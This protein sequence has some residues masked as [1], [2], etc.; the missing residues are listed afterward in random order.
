MDETPHGVPHVVNDIAIDFGLPPEVPTDAPPIADEAVSIGFVP[1][2]DSP[3]RIIGVRG[4]VVGGSSPI[5]VATKKL[6]TLLDG[7]FVTV[8]RAYDDRSDAT[9]WEPDGKSVERVLRNPIQHEDQKFGWINDVQVSYDGR[10]FL[11]RPDSLEVFASDLSSRTLMDSP[12]GRLRQGHGAVLSESVWVSSEPTYPGDHPD[13]FHTMTP[14][15]SEVSSFC[16]VPPGIPRNL[17]NAPIPRPLARLSDE[18]FLAAPRGTLSKP[19]YVLEVWSVGGDLVSRV[20]RSPARGEEWSD[21]VAFG[22]TADGD[23]PRVHVQE[24]GA[25]LIWVY[26]R[27]RSSTWRDIED[28]AERAQA[29]DELYLSRLDILDPQTWKLVFSGVADSAYGVLPNPLRNTRA[30]HRDPPDGAGRELIHLKVVAQ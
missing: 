1:H 9:V 7:R 21:P 3:T 26:T 23:S 22:E 25:G 20:H 4:V 13:W 19:G 24:D 8:G 17:L 27:E 6:A 11:T 12:A 30:T 10:L 29:R 14:D 15:G 16:S 5:E 28:R 2:A 18:L